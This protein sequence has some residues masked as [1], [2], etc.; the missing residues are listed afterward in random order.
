M[1][2]KTQF[3]YSN[4]FLNL[5]IL[6]ETTVACILIYVPGLNSALSFS[7]VTFWPWVCGLPFFILMLAYEEGRKFVVRTWPNSWAGIELCR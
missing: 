1:T 5:S 3:H 6:F 7:P 2:N 4:W